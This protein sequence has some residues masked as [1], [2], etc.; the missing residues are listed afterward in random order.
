MRI[1]RQEK[2]DEPYQAYATA[3]TTT[4][5]S[6]KYSSTSSVYVVEVVVL[7]STASPGTYVVMAG[8][9]DSGADTNTDTDIYWYCRGTNTVSL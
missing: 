1:E 8:Q 3:T 5:T 6:L 4:T 9:P 7:H 2:Q